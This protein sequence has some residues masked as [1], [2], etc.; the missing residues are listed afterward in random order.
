M[1]QLTHSCLV[2]WNTD[3]ERSA[4]GAAMKSFPQTLARCW[5]ECKKVKS[6]E[7]SMAV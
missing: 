1:G 7:N 5:W 2:L 3:V 6:M 4:L